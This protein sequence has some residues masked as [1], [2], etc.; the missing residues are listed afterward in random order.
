MTRTPLE[1]KLIGLLEW[2]IDMEGP[3]PGSSEWARRVQQALAE[4]KGTAQ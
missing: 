4:A 2:L 3:Q 1:E